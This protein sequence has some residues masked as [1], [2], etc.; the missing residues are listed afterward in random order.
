MDRKSISS[1]PRRVADA[2]TPRCAPIAALWDAESQRR[3]DLRSPEH[4]AALIAAQG[5]H[6]AARATATRAR[7]ERKLAKASTR[8]PLASSRRAARTSHRAA[9]RHLRVTRA[10][11]RTAHRHYPPTLWAVTGRVHAVHTGATALAAWWWAW[12]PLAISAVVLAGHLAVL[13]L[14]HRSP[15]PLDLPDGLTAE[16]RRLAGR[17]DPR[18]WTAA[19]EERGLAGTLPVP[20]ELTAAGLVSHVRLD[21]RWTPA[22]LRARTAEIRALLGA[23]TD[24]RIEVSDGSHG[25]RATITLRTRSAADGIDLTGWEPG[26]PWGVDTV[27]GSPV[28]LLLGVRLLVAGVSGAGKSWSLRPLMAEA[29]ERPDHRLVLID[30]KRVEARCWQHRARTAVTVD[31]IA[32]VVDELVVEMDDR[33]AVIPAGEDVIEINTD[34]PRITVV[35]DEGSEL[36]AVARGEY[37]RIMDGL[38]SISR[39]GRAVEVIVVW[40]TQKPTMSG[41]TPGLDPQISGQITTRVALALSTAGECRVV[42][43][44]DATELG[45]HAHQL[46]RPGHALIRSGPESQ[47]H[48]VRVR[49]ISPREVIALPARPIWQGRAPLFAVPTVEA[50]QVD[51]PASNQDR[52]LDAVREG[53]TTVAAVAAATGLNKGTVS[54]QI[55]RLVGA[56]DL[57]RSGTG[58]VAIEMDP[59]DRLDTVRT[60]HAA[61]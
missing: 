37:A 29:S 7:R 23:R 44:E 14:G 45:W 18:W 22:A 27:T 53:H 40:T 61:S 30:L 57:V 54:A 3:R 21:G 15:G 4:L 19:A 12:W 55:K 11:L 9:R 28:H 5:A 25:D 10:A 48:P 47:P 33:L 13:W 46:P 38:R 6:R 49:A 41:P 1:A 20:A 26:A 60:A 32:A 17:L 16:E 8:W 58:I 43:G 52:V 39:I 50:A 24:L 42:M 35:V 59:P 2:L 56:G 31:E 34:R 36:L 51:R